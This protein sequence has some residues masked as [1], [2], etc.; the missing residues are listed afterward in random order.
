MTTRQTSPGS[1]HVVSRLVAV[2]GLAI[3]VSLTAVSAHASP[4]AHSARSV[5]VSDTAHLH[6]VSASGS[7]LN[8]SGSA[9]GTLPGRVKGRFNIGPRIS[10]SLTIY[11]HGGSITLKGSGAPTAQGVR[12]R[13]RGKL[14]ITGGTGKYAHAHGSGSFSGV[15]DR[16]SWAVTAK[17]TGTLSY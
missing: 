2:V 11:V 3:F 4:A 16:R 13:F 6:L 15:V 1:G 9:T 8:E 5:R 10:A 7:R 17:A 14:T 12:S